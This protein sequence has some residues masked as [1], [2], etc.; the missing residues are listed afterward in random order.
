MRRLVKSFGAMISSSLFRCL[1]RS[2]NFNTTMIFRQSLSTVHKVILRPFIFSLTLLLVALPL[3]FSADQLSPANTLPAVDSSSQNQRHLRIG[4]ALAG[5]GTRGCA[6]IGVIRALEKAGIK[7]DCIAGTSMGAIV[8]GLYASG[9]STDDIQQLI[10]SKKLV[11]GYDTVPIPLRIAVVP[12]F[13]IPHLF[14]YHPYDGLYRGGVF[15]DFIRKSAP[16][17]HREIEKFEMPFAAVASNIIDGKA[18]AIT[19]GCIGKAVQASS[20]I[21]FL[22]RPVEIGDKLFID[23]GIVLNLPVDQ[24]RDLGADF[25]IAVDVDDDLVKMEKKNFR[26]IGSV[27]TRALNMHLST[28]DAAQVKRADFVIHPDVT[29][30]DLLSRNLK[31]AR[32]AIASGESETDKLMAALRKKIQEQQVSIAD[33]QGDK[34]TVK[35]EQIQND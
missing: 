14:G 25:V 13:F 30:I 6:H 15:A 31:D 7:I 5:G 12:I 3:A 4:L 23:G 21:P 9:V 17:G 19:K 35:G 34:A 29:G 11:H 1:G 18:Y 8:G 27:A 10:M 28:I 16:E 20:A 22:R 2:K 26:K 33:K 32:K 24:T